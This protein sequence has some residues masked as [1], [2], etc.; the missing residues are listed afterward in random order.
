MIV[1]SGLP[2]PGSPATGLRQ[3]A[4]RSAT[5]THHKGARCYARATGAGERFKT[6]SALTAAIDESCSLIAAFCPVYGA[7]GNLASADHP[8]SEPVRTRSQPRFESVSMAR[9]NALRTSASTA[10]N[11]M[12]TV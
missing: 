6:R 12:S 7:S 8:P 11:P 1:V 5:W 4:P 10:A 3:P 2:T 9:A